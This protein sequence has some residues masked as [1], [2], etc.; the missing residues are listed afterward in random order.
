M[1]AVLRNRV[2]ARIGE[3]Q[4]RPVRDAFESVAG[5]AAN[6]GAPI[7]VEVATP[8]GRIHVEAL[9]SA[10]RRVQTEVA[11]HVGPTIGV[12]SGF[13]AMDGD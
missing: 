2:R 4:A 8:Q 10:L 9:Q 6:V 3:E 5:A 11:S 13:N 1:R 12:T 7:D